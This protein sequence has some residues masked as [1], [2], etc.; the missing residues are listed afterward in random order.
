MV[1]SLRI[2]TWVTGGI[3]KYLMFWSFVTRSMP[4][5]LLLKGC[6]NKLTY[7]YFQTKGSSGGVV[8]VLRRSNC[9]LTGL[10]IAGE[11]LGILGGDL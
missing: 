5:S 8:L 7:I 11:H 1:P 3:L 10:W 6:G 4:R 2:R 9:C